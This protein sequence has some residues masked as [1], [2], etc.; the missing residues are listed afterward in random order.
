[1][2]GKVNLNITK[3]QKTWRKIFLKFIALPA[4]IFYCGDQR[5]AVNY[6]D[7]KFFHLT[8]FDLQSYKDLSLIAAFRFTILD[9]IKY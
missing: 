1:M 7:I 5:A 9:L 3:I 8:L 4:F 2:T 6:R